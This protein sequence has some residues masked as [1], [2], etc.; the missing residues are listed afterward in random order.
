[1]DDFLG[2][3]K[4]GAEKVAWE[5]EKLNRQAQAKSELE[6]IR[7]TLQVK[8]AEL[9]KL[10]YSQKATGSDT[11]AAFDELCQVVA[12]F[13]E[14]LKTKNEEVQ[15]IT[16][17]VYSPGVNQQNAAASVPPPPP[18]AEPARATKFCSSCGKEM[19]KEAKFCPNCG[20]AS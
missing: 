13:E 6:N 17:E 3:L 11:G 1:M 20:A 14:Q 10:V 9:G 8:Y 2:K 5:A 18:S 7:A 16:A 12:G 15:R 19:P 4:S